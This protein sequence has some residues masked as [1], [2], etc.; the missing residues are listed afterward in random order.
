MNCL[1][2]TILSM[3]S[4]KHTWVVFSLNH[5]TLCQRCLSGDTLLVFVWKEQWL[6]CSV[7]YPVYCVGVRWDIQN[8]HHVIECDRSGNTW[9]PVHPNTCTILFKIT[10]PEVSLI[11]RRKENHNNQILSN[12]EKTRRLVTR[13]IWDSDCQKYSVQD[14]YNYWQASGESHQA[15]MAHPAS[16]WPIWTFPEVMA[17]W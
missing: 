15:A 4:L 10:H 1:L 2:R 16:D 9:D 11:P 14:R 12:F 8:R 13:Q 7:S 17:A 5:S 6:N 3:V